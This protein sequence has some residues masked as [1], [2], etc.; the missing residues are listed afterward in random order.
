MAERKKS[1]NRDDVNGDWARREHER[2]QEA[3]AEVRRAELEYNRRLTDLDAAAKIRTLTEAITVLQKIKDELNEIFDLRPLE[4]H[5]PPGRLSLRR[6]IVRYLWPV[7]Q[8]YIER[9]SRFNAA[10]VHLLNE[11]IDYTIQLSEQLKTLFHLSIQYYQQIIPLVDAKQREAVAREDFNV[12]YNIGLVMRELSHSMESIYMDILRRI[13]ELWYIYSNY[14]L[15]EERSALL[16]NEG[17]DWESIKNAFLEPPRSGMKA[18]PHI[19]PEHFRLQ[20][21]FSEF[22]KLKRRIEIGQ[23]KTEELQEPPERVQ[24][25][26][27]PNARD[28]RYHVFESIFRGEPEVIERR[29]ERYIPIFKSAAGPIIDIGCGRGEFLKLM[30][31]LGKEAYGLEISRY[32]VER[33]REQGFDVRPEDAVHHLKRLDDEF[34]GGAFCAQVVEHLHPEEVFTLIQELFRTMKPGAPLVI[35]TVNITSVYAFHHLYHIDPTHIYPVHPQT[36]V[37]FLRYA[38]FGD[39]SAHFM[40]EI[41]SEVKLPE[42]A[43]DHSDVGQHLNRV[44]RQLNEWLYGP[45]EY[46]VIGYR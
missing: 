8:P 44:V 16:K 34:L 18:Y 23:S 10:L 11:W 5:Y 17:T 43:E 13:H 40:A 45:L 27:F 22:E 6:R 28:F 25:W 3:T 14:L 46:Y 15:K 32:E 41:P 1:G 36:L 31:R 12:T 21:L 30:K 24:K 7:F 35:E 39:V 29:F 9:Q 37:F 19:R 33:L 38:G 26:E 42:I 2:L 20:Q 4:G